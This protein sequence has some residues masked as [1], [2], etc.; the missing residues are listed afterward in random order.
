MKTTRIV[1]LAG[2]MLLTSRAFADVPKEAACAACPT[3]KHASAPQLTAPATFNTAKGGHVLWPLHLIT[4]VPANFYKAEDHQAVKKLG[5]KIVASHWIEAALKDYVPPGKKATHTAIEAEAFTQQGRI[6][7]GEAIKFIEKQIKAHPGIKHTGHNL[8]M[9]FL[10]EGLQVVKDPKD[11]NAKVPPGFH[12][13]FPDAMALGDG[14]AAIQPNKACFERDGFSVI[15]SHEL[16][17]A[18]TDTAGLG[19]KLRHAAK[20]TAELVAEYSPWIAARNEVGDLCAAARIVD[21]GVLYERTYSNSAAAAGGDP[22]APA[23]PG[24]YFNTTPVPSSGPQP[25]F[26]SWT[27][28]QAGATAMIQLQGW[29]SGRSEQCDYKWQI[30]AKPIVAKAKKDD[31]GE[32]D[33][34]T[35]NEQFTPSVAKLSSTTI[36]NNDVVTLTVKVPPGTPAGQWGVVQVVSSPAVPERDHDQSQSWYYGVYTQ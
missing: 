12:N 5:D 16:A 17:E 31:D 30:S 2:M 3:P 1:V 28:A 25:G 19:Y 36:G 23:A 15:M 7:H 22:C 32:Q 20:P 10:P 29:I 35:N 8:Y 26:V 18:V 6:S 9:L 33:D 24:T 21:D 34:D 27:R 4:L 14:W 13:S 11:A